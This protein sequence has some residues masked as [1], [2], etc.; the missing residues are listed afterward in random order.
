MY[1]AS[2]PV[3]NERPEEEER[4]G[5]DTTTHPFYEEVDE[6][7]MSM[8]QYASL[9]SPSASYPGDSVLVHNPI[10]GSDEGG[11]G[12]EGVHT[13]PRGHRDDQTTYYY[14]DTLRGRELEASP[15]TVDKKHIYDYVDVKM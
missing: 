14:D 15:T 5:Q 9:V 4:E 10:Y 1:N 7:R 6:A 3:N 12:N 8:S 2:E 11:S 13:S